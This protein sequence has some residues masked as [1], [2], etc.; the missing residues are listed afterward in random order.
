MKKKT[1][2]LIVG[3]SG[4]GKDSIV[5][6]LIKD[7]PELSQIKSYTTRQ[8]RY[9]EGDTHKFISGDEVWFFKNQM[10]AY[11]FFNGN[12]YFATVEQARQH[13]FYVIDPKGV[14]YMRKVLQEKYPKE[15]N[16][17]T[18]NIKTSLPR[19]F[20]RMLKRGDGI[21]KAIQR[22]INDQKEFEGFVGD[23]TI[24]NNNFSDSVEKLNQIYNMSQITCK[25]NCKCKKKGVD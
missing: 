17:I 4:S 16:I 7:R 6:E 24:V 2:F 21:K 15:F 13:D 10:I 5:Q 9:K 20:T 14:N 3:E 11:T 25:G 23:Y 1:L 18:V 12:H 8:P 22:L 19:R